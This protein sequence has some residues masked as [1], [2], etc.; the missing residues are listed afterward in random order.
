MHQSGTFRLGFPLATQDC[1]S[2]QV[3]SLF[4]P[5]RPIGIFASYLFEEVL[6][7]RIQMLSRDE[8]I[9]M[10]APAKKSP[11]SGR[12]PTLVFSR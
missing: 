6:L 10:L 3:F 5:N 8:M 9:W 4:V 1:R 7:F 2:F 11:L 12:Y